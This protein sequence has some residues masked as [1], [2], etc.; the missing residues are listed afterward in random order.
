M[1]SRNFNA[2]SK[3]AGGES[4]REAMDPKVKAE[5]D[6][7]M[8]A[9]QEARGPTLVEQ[10]RLKREQERNANAGGSQG[11]EWNW[12]RD[13]DLDSGRRVDKNALAMVL[14]GASKDLKT[15][16]QGGF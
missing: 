11:G 4:M 3:L 7:I 2:K 14:G 13:K 12:N 10:H 6:A 5:M 9:H 16:F 1:K 8:A 15:K